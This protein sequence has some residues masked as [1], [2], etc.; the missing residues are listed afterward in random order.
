M[1]FGRISAVAAAT[2]MLAA[3]AA[4][5]GEAEEELPTAGG[6]QSANDQEAQGSEEQMVAYD[7]CM[8]EHGVDM[9][10]EGDPVP[11]DI[12][13]DEET[14]TAAMEECEDLMPTGELELDEDTVEEM[15][16][17]AECMRD[18]GI[19]MP[20]PDSDGA[21]DLEGVDVQSDE[22]AEADASC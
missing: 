16:L 18:E 13:I 2:V 9:P 11:E 7:E 19:D 22:Y 1:N 5:S 20:D 10:E 17:W 14:L 15:R 8:R 4:C 3:T 21:M 6:E 12:D